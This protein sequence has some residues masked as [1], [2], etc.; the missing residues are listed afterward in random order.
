M[1]ACLKDGLLTNL[2]LKN[3]NPDSFILMPFIE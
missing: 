3:L 1:Q 2:I